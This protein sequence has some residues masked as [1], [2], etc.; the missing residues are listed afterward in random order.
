MEHVKL[1]LVYLVYLAALWQL[2]VSMVYTRC[3]SLLKL[4]S[5]QSGSLLQRQFI[6]RMRLS[7]F[8]VCAV[9]VLCSVFLC[10]YSLASGVINE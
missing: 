4:L 8:I 7:C 1:E 3:S 10:L 5:F 6:S 2:L 9:V